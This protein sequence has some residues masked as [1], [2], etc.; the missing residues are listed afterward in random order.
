MYFFTNAKDNM[1]ND[2]GLFLHIKSLKKPDLKLEV[3]KEN[4]FKLTS[5]LRTFMWVNIDTDLWDVQIIKNKN[6]LLQNDL[7]IKNI[8]SQDVNNITYTNKK[9]Y[10]ERWSKY[11]IDSLFLNQNNFL[12][13]NEIWYLNQFKSKYDWSYN[14]SKILNYGI[15]NVKE[16][17]TRNMY[18]TL[19]WY[20]QD[21]IN[22]LINLKQVK[23]DDDKVKWYRKLIKSDNLPPIFVWYISSLYAYIIIDGHS[24]LKASLLENK[25]PEIIAIYS[26]KK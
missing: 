5:N 15:F 25:A 2:L 21:D 20:S 24:R 11:F 6:E 7:I 4:K 8:S 16:A 23:E 3:Y 9:E 14:N 22:G 13:N 18:D 19:D 10:F 26:L 1:N 12:N 17:I